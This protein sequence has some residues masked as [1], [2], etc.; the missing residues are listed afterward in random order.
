M[1]DSRGGKMWYVIHTMAGLEQK[2][3]Q[4]CQ[5][6]IDQSAYQ[7]MFIRAGSTRSKGIPTVYQSLERWRCCFAGQKRG[8]GVPITDDG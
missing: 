3:M 4:Q 6:Y 7:E 8:T 5:E 2:C 1:L